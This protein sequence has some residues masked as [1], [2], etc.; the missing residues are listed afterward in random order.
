[1]RNGE[2]DTN[3]DLFNTDVKFDLSELD[4]DAVAVVNN[5]INSNNLYLDGDIGTSTSTNTYNLTVNNTKGNIELRDSSTSTNYNDVYVKNGST[6][7]FNSA[8]V[9]NINDL[10]IKDSTV[11]LL[12]GGMNVFGNMSMGSTYNMMNGAINTLNVAGNLTLTDDSDFLI[13]IN[14]IL[15]QSDTVVI[16]GNLA[17]DSTTVRSLDVSDW[18][19]LSEPVAA[20]SVYNVFNVQGSVD[21]VVFTT[22]KSVLN[23]PIAN[24]TFSSLGNGSYMLAR[25]GYTSTAYAVPVAVQAGYM[26]QLA[27]YDMAF[28]NLDTVMTLPVLGYDNQYA[29]AMDDTIV[30]SPLF[31]PELEKGIWFRPYGNFEKVEFDDG[32]DVDN[33]SYGAYVGGDTPLTELGK[34]FQGNM[35]AYIGY[36]GSHQSFSGTSNYQNAGTVGVT[37]ALYKGGFFSGLTVNVTAGG[38]D[39]STPYG[40]TDFFM[41]GVGVASKTGYNWELAR[42]KFIIQPSWLMSYSFVNPFSPGNLA[43]YN[44]D[45]DG[46]HGVQLSPHIKFIANLPYGWQPYALFNFRWNLADDAKVTINSVDIPEISIKPY[47]EYGI[48]VQKRWG[49]RFTGYG[50]FLGR[51]IGRNG[52]GLNFG[53]RWSVGQGR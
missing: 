19:L 41:L 20:A 30:Y 28:G 5:V 45:A 37:G 21:N 31:I 15:N 8:G 10:V 48:G 44:V 24:Y 38:N 9:T 18:N 2:L 3:G 16:G 23:T 26:N 1:M 29:N 39:S 7:S 35:S 53:F 52:V 42:G 47:V 43:G 11:K 12:A 17:S 27:S 22:S 50:Q 49:E 51:G 33:Q 46:L 4:D 40:K 25:N 36:N 13:D 34:G 32:P 6:A 14:P